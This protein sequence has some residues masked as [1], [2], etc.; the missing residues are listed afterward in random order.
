[1]PQGMICRRSSVLSGSNFVV[2]HSFRDVR[3]Y[4]DIILLAERDGCL[5]HDLQA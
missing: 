1:M 2:K 5:V 3:A 4:R